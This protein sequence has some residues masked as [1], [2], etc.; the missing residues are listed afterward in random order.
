VKATLA[1]KFA[2]QK[3][4][5][6]GFGYYYRMTHTSRSLVALFVLFGMTVCLA[7][8]EPP[9]RLVLHTARHAPGDLEIGGS[10]QGVPQGETR[11]VSYHQL[12]S[13]PQESYTVSDDTNFGHTVQI[14]GV[15]LDTLPKWLG[16]QIYA[17]MVIAICDDRYAAHYPASYLSAHHPLLVLK[18][19]G[20]QPAQWPLSLD[21]L[22]MGPFMVSH[23]SFT[24]SFHVLS[25]Q[26]EA[27]IPWGVVRID[28]RREQ[29]VDAPIEPH[30]SAAKDPAVQAGYA[31]ARQNCF[32]CHSR[33]GEGGKKSTVLWDDIARKAVTDPQRFD[34]YVRFPTRINP[35]SK[36]AA[37]PQ[38]DDA[39][40]RALR[41][42]FSCF[43]QGGT[44]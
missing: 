2:I 23:P 19:N 16:A 5:L 35:R 7:A 25:H 10:L 1:C 41:L 44:R 8:F 4:K 32:R 15:A 42:Y 21:G 6:S 31:I 26:D 14:S 40:L 36:M 22:A 39:T 9:Q 20:Q 37:S 29:T 38:Y 33:F 11:F 12:L 30:A 43:A 28:V 13:L 17:T 34:A 24:P 18:V 27:Q 3:W